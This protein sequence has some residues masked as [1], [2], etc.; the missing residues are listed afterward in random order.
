MDLLATFHQA[1]KIMQKNSPTILTALGVAGLITTVVMAVYATPKAVEIIKQEEHERDLD[2]EEGAPIEPITVPE[3]IRLAWKEYIPSAIM[4]AATI[5]CIVGS[6]SVNI[7]RNSALAA[8]FSLTE[9]AAREY[10]EKVKEVIGEKKEQEVRDEIAQDAVDKH[11][12]KDNSIVITGNGNT[13]CFDKLSGR[14]FS[15]NINTIKKIELNYNQLLLR[16][17]YLSLN[18]LYEE[19]GLETIPM[20]EDLGWTTKYFLEFKFSSRLTPDQEPCL[21]VDYQVGPGRI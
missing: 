9:T 14:Y 1:N 11:P 13:L 10:R 21:V 18:C 15:S 19:L 17:D 2:N 5:A 4:G 7:R 12:L 8:L 20:G 6:N 3:V 16:R